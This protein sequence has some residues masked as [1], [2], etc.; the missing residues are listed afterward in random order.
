M[1]CNNS[2]KFTVAQ[3]L[4]CSAF[5]IDNLLECDVFKECHEIKVHLKKISLSIAELLLMKIYGIIRELLSAILRFYSP[6]LLEL[7]KIKES[8]CNSHISRK[9]L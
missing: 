9:C 8:Y 3:C 6:F 2:Y 1:H 7:L 4:K 5:K